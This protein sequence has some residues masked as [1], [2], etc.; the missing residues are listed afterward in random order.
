MFK[1]LFHDGLKIFEIYK[2]LY[3]PFKR[4]WVARKVFLYKSF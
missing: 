4:D 1:E 2:D 3:E